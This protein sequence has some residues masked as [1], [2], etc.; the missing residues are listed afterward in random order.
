M[1]ALHRIVLALILVWIVASVVFLAIRLVPGD[2]AELMLSQAGMTPDP[3]TVSELRDQLGLNLPV[4]VQYWNNLRAVLSGDLGASL[5]DQASVAGQVFIRLPRTLELIAAAS[6]LS[7][8][9]GVP[10]GTLAAFKRGGW[11]DGTVMAAAGLSLSVP[12]FV[13]G[14]LLVL[15]LAQSLSLLPA[16]GFTPLLSNPARHVAQLLMPALTIAI[17]LT[18]VLLSMTRASMLDVIQRDHVRTARAKGVHPSGVVL[19]HILRNALMP[20]VTVLALHL[21]TLLGGTVLVEYVFNY[22]G[23]SGLLVDAVNAR[24]YPMVQGVVLVISVL[25]VALNLLMDLIYGVL[26]PRARQG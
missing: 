21:G 9:I 10:L 5:T 3:A 12:V 16:G 23:L 4:W 22:P 18:P 19:R 24:D 1:W 25:F 20:V 8:L 6:F 26:D 2:P 14:T 15:V 17:N 7:V 11:F 13:T